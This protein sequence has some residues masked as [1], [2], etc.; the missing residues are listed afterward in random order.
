MS[1][2]RSDLFNNF[3]YL[4]HFFG[5]FKQKRVSESKRIFK[6]RLLKKPRDR[7]KCVDD[8]ISSTAQDTKKKKKNPATR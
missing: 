4:R 3:P 5:F 6:G 7:G 1:K 2:A 8:E